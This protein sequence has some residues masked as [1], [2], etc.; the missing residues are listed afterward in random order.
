M[1]DFSGVIENLAFNSF[2]RF[3]LV[4]FPLSFVRRIV[5]YLLGK[6]SCSVSFL[7]GPNTPVYFDGKMAKLM[8]FWTP[9]PNGSG[10]ALSL[11]THANQLRLGAV[12][13][14]KQQCDPSFL[15]TAFQR[16]VEDLSKHLSQ[17]T[18]P[19]HLR[20]RAKQQLQM[21]DREDRNRNTSEEVV[22]NLVSFPVRWCHSLLLISLEYVVL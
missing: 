10:V 15:L 14:Q 4:I 1:E 2:L 5:D 21:E 13:H 20:W 8:T 7:T 12:V 11:A 19:S 17:R 16:E 9:K 3:C 22:W 18:L 6:A